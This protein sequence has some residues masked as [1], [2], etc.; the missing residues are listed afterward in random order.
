[1]KWIMAFMAGLLLQTAIAATVTFNGSVTNQVIDGFGVNVNHRSWHNDEL[2]PVLDAFIDQAGM[3]LFRVVFDQAD[4][5]TNNDN[6]DP[7]VMDWGYYGSVYGSA[8]LVP[9]WEML[10]YLNS[11][12]ITDGAFLN[13]M[14]HGPPWLSGSDGASL[15]SGKEG[16]WAEMITSLLMYARFTNG[17]QFK[18]VAPDNEPDLYAEG[19]EILTASQYVL[20]LHQLAERLA[21]N[22]LADVRIIG[23]D[24]SDYTTTFMPEMMADSVVI[25][26][27]GKFGAHSYGGDGTGAIYN[28]IHSSPYPDRNLWVT[29]FNVWCSGCDT[30][31]RG[32]YDWTYCKG[33]ANYLLQHLLYGASAGMVWEGYDS[34]YLHGGPSW[35]FWGLIGVDNEN[36]AVKTYTPRKNFYTVAQISKWVRPGAQRIGI[37]GSVS[38]L[39]PLLAFKHSGLGQVTIVGINTSGSAVT[40]SGALASLPSVSQ[41]DLYYTSATNNLAY[42]GSVAV[43][44]GS[45]N[46]TIPAD[47]VFTLTGFAGVQVVM[48]S[49]ANGARF[50]APATVPLG[51]TAATSS[52]GIAYVRFYAGSSK[53]SDLTNAPYEFN[54]TNVP[55]GDYALTAVATDT[56]GNSAT[57]T[58]V[59]ITVAGPMAQIAV[60]PA[61]VAV[62][63]GG[64]QQFYAT[65]GDQ[66]GHVLAPQP[67]FAW[68]VSGGGTIDN[69]GLFSAGSSAGGPFNVAAAS[70]GL[71]GTASVSVTAVSGG[72]IGN[73]KE[74]TSTDTMWDNGAWIN[75]ARFAANSNLVVSTMS[76]KVGAISGGYKCAVYT[77]QSGSPSALLGGTVEIRSPTNGWNVFPLAASIT[78]TNGQYYWLAIWSDDANAKVYYSDNNGSLRWGQYNYGNWPNPIA[79]T[80]GNSVN[81][82]IYAS[83]PT[84]SLVSPIVVVQPKGQ[85]VNLGS[86][87]IFTVSAAGDSPLLY[88]WYRNLTNALAGDINDF[89]ILTNV[90][91]ADAGWYSVLVSNAAGAM[92]SSNAQLVINHLPVPASPALARYWGSGFSAPESVFLGTDP[93]GD[94]LFISW[95]SPLSAC[96]AAVSSAGRWV[97]YAPPA[98]VT[99]DDTFG[100]VVADGRGGFGQGTASVVMLTERGP[101]LQALWENRNAGMLRII[102]SGISNRRYTL[103]FQEGLGTGW[104]PIATVV[105]DESG[106]FAYVTSPA[107]GASSRFYRVSSY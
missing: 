31:T 83:G 64:T 92:M 37:S 100:Y 43:N 20:A 3:T 57:S 90:T 72:T 42:G 29:E 98:G 69:T 65:A 62:S 18:Y 32:N 21:T 39:S 87:A 23:P 107:P 104:Q 22:G 60:A 52:G 88:Q 40:L 51:A 59:N 33:T 73:T 70:G 81:Y 36:A 28:Y 94:G 85:I 17:L 91:D 50:N 67:A 38:S 66:K 53:L 76:V 93:D 89:L 58:V 46:A 102:G 55:M 68:S 1:M 44:N 78:L 5:E 97:T 19:I 13:F 99:N 56:A 61:S 82:C 105:S 11:R 47:S 80:G 101:T 106:S 95:V 15:A 6:G 86:N 35:S 4:W 103:E 7:A 75:L 27:L 71:V 30:G 77:D 9:L 63:T 24:R 54:W 84:A 41:L 96:G 8:R 16:E 12:G 25:Q 74:G 48:A 10:G 79:T 34:Y 45:F 2:K 49:P 26:Q 14:G